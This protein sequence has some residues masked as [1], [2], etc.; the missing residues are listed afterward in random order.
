MKISMKNY[1][2]IL[3]AV[4]TALFFSPVISKALS[5]G[6][7]KIIIHGSAVS[8][9]DGDS[10]EI[11][12]F[13]YGIQHPALLITQGDKVTK[14]SY[15][16]NFSH[17]DMPIHFDIT[18]YRN[19]K[20]IG[21]LTGGI[22]TEPG[23]SI[24]IQDN[25][26][27]G[28]LYNKTFTGKGSQKLSCNLQ[29]LRQ[30]EIFSLKYPNLAA[31]NPQ[32]AA[33]FDSLCREERRY[34]R[35]YN[36][37]LS[38]YARNYLTC[39]A[40]LFC[41]QSKYLAFSMKGVKS[42][43]PFR[44]KQFQA[45]ITGLAQDPRSGLE[46]MGCLSYYLHVQNRYENIDHQ[47]RDATKL[48]YMA[49]RKEYTGPLRE[50]LITDLLNH[51][52]SSDLSFCIDDAMGLMK[53]PVLKKVLSGIRN[54]TGIGQHAFNFSLPDTALQLHALSDYTNTVVVLDFWFTGC[55]NCR[56]LKPFLDTLENAC[57][58]QAVKF[59]TVS[60]DKDFVLWKQSVLS[61]QYTS[62]TALNV[63]SG[64]LKNQDRNIIAEYNISAYPTIILID[65]KGNIAQSPVDPRLD[66]GEN[67]KQLLQD[68][69]LR[70]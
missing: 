22:F 28:N 32:K 8:L 21:N 16:F 60:I 5:P 12:G 40:I 66:C 23:D 10:I 13:R 51:V 47:N 34:I 3:P 68:L 43:F 19:D 44:N 70:E 61:G 7:R 45:I 69:L 46:Y 27:R 29:L 55:G 6:N 2:L 9:R 17:I 50:I 39:T 14:G 59:I 24:L 41:E 42:N 35:S 57:S 18:Y 53:M 58:H 65:R 49:I 31:M 54:K 63:W 4:W 62:G 38:R 20:I 11:R 25:G 56:R 30:N 33:S 36:G 37:K 26:V 67:M 1:K 15:H 64:R 48:Q 52:H